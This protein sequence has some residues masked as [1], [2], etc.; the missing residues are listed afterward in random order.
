MVKVDVTDYDIKHGTKGNAHSCPIARATNRVLKEGYHSS[1]GIYIIV[2]DDAGNNVYEEEPSG[3]V[4]EFINYFDEGE[5][6]EYRVREFEFNI[7]IEYL[8]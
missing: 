2:L 8:K 5:I 6:E 3:E 1:I 7:P 4:E